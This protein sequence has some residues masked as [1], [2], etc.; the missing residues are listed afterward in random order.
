MS[1]KSN[2]LKELVPMLKTEKNTKKTITLECQDQIVAE[3]AFNLFVG[4]QSDFRADMNRMF[5]N[6]GLGRLDTNFQNINLDTLSLE[7]MSV[8]TDKGEI[9]L[10]KDKA[11]VISSYKKLSNGD[12]Y[13]H[14]DAGT[15]KVFQ[16]VEEGAD[17]HIHT[18][19]NLSA[20]VEMI[21]EFERQYK[22]KLEEMKKAASDAEINT[23]IEEKV[24]E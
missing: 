4:R 17:Q 20:L 18:A 22:E 13:G 3:V 14:I 8:P 11:I 2:K 21:V 16:F 19:G 1:K 23:K 9:F 12:F 5:A 24:T 15:L 6:R 10:V 7:I